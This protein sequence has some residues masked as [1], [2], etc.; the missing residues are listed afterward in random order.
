MALPSVAARIRRDGANLVV[1]NQLVKGEDD[2]RI[3]DYSVTKLDASLNTV[4]SKAYDYHRNDIIGDITQASQA[5]REGT[6]EKHQPQ[7]ENTQD[8]E[9]RA[10]GL[11]LGQAAALGGQFGQHLGE[12]ALQ[13]VVVRDDPAGGRDLALGTRPWERRR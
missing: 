10:Q 12:L 8:I 1:L 3:T 9:R 6:R 7:S 11:Q 4:F 5:Q 13:D 2:D